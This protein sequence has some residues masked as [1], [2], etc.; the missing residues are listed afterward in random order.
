MKRVGLLLGL[1]LAIPLQ[2]AAL[3]GVDL[4]LL[5]PV[6]CVGSSE[7]ANVC[8]Y[9]FPAVAGPGVLQIT[10]GDAGGSGRVSAATVSLN[11]SRIVRTNQLNQQVGS[12]QVSVALATAN[13]L[14]VR[15][16]TTPHAHRAALNIR[17]GSGGVLPR[18]HHRGGPSYGHAVVKED[19]RGG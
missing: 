4:T 6:T 11:G 7:G 8:T 14:V 10:N 13:T 19:G 16:S 18:G 3:A 17:Q 15:V 1:L 2:G 5:S 9:T 12:L